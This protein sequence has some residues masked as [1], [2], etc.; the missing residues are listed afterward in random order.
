[1]TSLSNGDLC[2]LLSQ[3]WG[4]GSRLE[5]GSDGQL[6]ARNGSRLPADIVQQIRTH[7]TQLVKVLSR[8]VGLTC[9]GCGGGQVAVPTFDGYENLECFHCGKCSGCRRVQR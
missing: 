5:I 6:F 8:S 1:M 4:G 9:P 7:K 2:E 3:I